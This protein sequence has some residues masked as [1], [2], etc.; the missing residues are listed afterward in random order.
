VT[1]RLSFTLDGL[2][3]MTNPSGRGTH[4]R[5]IAGER[6]KWKTAVWAAAQGKLPRQPLVTFTLHLTRF[7]SVAPDY[8]GLVSGFKAIVDGLREARVIAD[9]KIVNTGPWRCQWIK[10]KRDEGRV[11]V[12]VE[13]R[14]DLDAGVQL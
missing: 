3:R 13:D 1:Y 11:S 2:P 10:C 9:D 12:T 8:D 5:T 14:D 6:R 7:S 4:W